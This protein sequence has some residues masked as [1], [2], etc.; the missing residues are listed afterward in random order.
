MHYLNSQGL[1]TQ[2]LVS[3]QQ[4]QKKVAP[5]EEMLL[6]IYNIFNETSL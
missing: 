6:V 2:I 4:R 3:L 5:G 1:A